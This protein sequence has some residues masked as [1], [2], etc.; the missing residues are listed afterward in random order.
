[1]LKQVVAMY[2]E[3]CGAARA[4]CFVWI[5]IAKR[6]GFNKDVRK[7]IA[8]LVGMQEEWKIEFAVSRFFLL[9]FFL[10]TLLALRPDYYL[11]LPPWRS[12]FGDTR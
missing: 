12:F 10:F 2:D 6:M 4:A 11:P 5:L 9:D 3:W 7:M 1:M 8:K